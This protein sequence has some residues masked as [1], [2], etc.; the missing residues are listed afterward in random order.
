MAQGRCTNGPNCDI[1]HRIPDDD[2]EKALGP[3]SDIFG[4]ERYA[5]ERED[6]G[7][8]GT[9]SRENRTLYVG[10]VPS[11]RA[12]VQDAVRRAFG[13]FGAL[14]HVKV[15]ADR[16]CAFAK[17]RLR[18]AAEFAKEALA[19]QP[20][21]AG[22]EPMNLRCPPSSA[23]CSVLIKRSGHAVHGSPP[24]LALRVCRTSTPWTTLAYV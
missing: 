4:R 10:R 17:Y 2:D 1:W 15:L 23:D 5:S 7:G 11:G 3:A 18:A 21:F 19:E 9:F 24:R 20:L 16:N 13:A 14:E 8:I 22:G 6:M 12:G